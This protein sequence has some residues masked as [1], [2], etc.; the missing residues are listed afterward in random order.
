MFDLLRFPTE[1]GLLLL[2]TILTLVVGATV[3]LVEPAGA[4]DGT[5]WQVAG[6][7]RVMLVFARQA[8]AHPAHGDDYR[9]KLAERI[10]A[11]AGRHDVPLEV[12]TAITQRESGFRV[13]IKRGG[14]GEIGL[15]QVHP[16]TAK[17]FDCDLSTV[18]GQLDCGSKIIKHGMEKCGSI[19]GAL[20][21]YGSRRGQCKSKKGTRLHS[22]VKSRSRLIEKHRKILGG[23]N[24]SGETGTETKTSL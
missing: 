14:R 21:V 18:Y 4:Q 20:N 19:E 7:E 6:V 9:L 5:Q 1:A 16:G 8:P 3:A 11:A 24:D 15:T 13:K 12:M 2:M 23:N 17:L 22:V 10:V